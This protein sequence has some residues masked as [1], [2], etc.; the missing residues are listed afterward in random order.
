MSSE[1]SKPLKY[2]ITISQ[3]A[4]VI[5]ILIGISKWNR[6]QTIMRL[7]IAILAAWLAAEIIQFITRSNSIHNLWISYALTPIQLIL[8]G[9]YFK[10]L[11]P[12]R[13][14]LIIVLFGTGLMLAAIETIVRPLTH[15]NSISLLYQCFIIVL[16]GMLAF[17]G[18]ISKGNF[19]FVWSC[20]A[21]II[22][23]M[24]SAVYYAA[25]IKLDNM[26]LLRMLSAGHTYL[27]ILTYSLITV[28]V[29]KQ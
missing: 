3:F 8:M 18:M 9:F 7:V 13:R 26:D 2:L 29:W 20:A 23:F 22:L 11:M 4:S 17:Y 24:G 25:F 14:I 12:E 27:L 6:S 10:L 16:I 28:E 21:F 19:V 1:L 5:P 15:L